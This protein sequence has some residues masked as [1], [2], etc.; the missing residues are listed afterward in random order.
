[1]PPWQEDQFGIFWI[2]EQINHKL[3]GSL[4]WGGISST[5]Q[6]DWA[7]QRDR[8]PALFLFQHSNSIAACSGSYTA[9]S[10]QPGGIFRNQV[11][12]GGAPCRHTCLKTGNSLVFGELSYRYFPGS[13]QN[14]SMEPWAKRW[15]PKP[16]LG[17]WYMSFLS[18]P[19]HLFSSFPSPST[20]P[21][22]FRSLF[23]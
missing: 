1:M 10:T 2:R 3:V 18:G 7:G 6:T 16:E 8:L 13:N 11:T 23:S 12:L 20:L 22:L 9:H 19:P 21:P 5:R 14:V 4:E 15:A 17:P